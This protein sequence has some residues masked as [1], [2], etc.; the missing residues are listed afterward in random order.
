[1]SLSLCQSVRAA[2]TKDR[3]AGDLNNR[4]LF[5]HS[6]R[7]QTSK[8]KVSGGFLLPEVSLLGLQKATVL[9]SPHSVIC[10]CS[11]DVLM[12]SFCALISFYFK[13]TNQIRTTLTTP[14]Q[15]NYL[16]LKWIT[17]VCTGSCCYAGFLQ[18][19]QVGLFS[20]CSAQAFHCSGFSL[21]RARA[22]GCKGSVVVTL[23][24]TCRTAYGLFLDQGSN[25]YPWYRQAVS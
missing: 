23:Q 7:G 18:L 12:S 4:H 1:M 9:P 8:I 2:I 11:H 13:D 14:F 5:S 21:C 10:L 24:L 6:P 20:N 16:F 17:F 22:P 19:R 15:L 25:L 3:R